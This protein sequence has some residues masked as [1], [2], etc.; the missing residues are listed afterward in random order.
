MPAIISKILENSIADEVG[1]AKGD[2]IL[3]INGQQPL[4]YIDY[5]FS[6]ASEDIV[7]EVQKSNFDIEII[8]I[9]KDFNE[10][11]GIVFESAI[12]DKIK[13]CTNKCI[14]CFVDQQPEGLRDSLYIK[15]DDYRLSYLQGTYVT[16]TNL[17]EKDRQRI[18]NLR[19]GPLYISVHTTNPDLRVK[20]LRNPKASKILEELSWLKKIKIPVHIQI[21]LCPGINDGR[22][23]ERTLVDLSNYKSIIKSI[24]VVPV[25]VTKYRKEKLRKIDKEVALKTIKQIENFNLKIKKNI[26]CASDEFFLTAD[27]EIPPTKY[28]GKFSQLEDGVGTLRLILDDF[29]KRIKKV[30]KRIKTPKK[31]TFAVSKSAYK[32]FSLFADELNKI[33]NLQIEII[34]V[35]SNY[36][37]SDI[38]VAGLICATDIIEQLKGRE[39]KNL[40]ISSV[41]LKAYSNE[42][43][44]GKTTD[45]IEKNLNCRIHIIY[46]FYSTKEIFQMIFG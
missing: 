18:E 21:V 42:F 10:D 41:M 23:L 39:I 7:L 34:P 11:L 22:E 12:F 24:A 37:G 45:D 32:V 13:P 35:K 43:L 36:W 30:P 27:A 28:Y 25:G 16:L 20:M 46:D 5:N 31:F 19:L 2:V 44:D 17:N 15:D 9:E 3:K 8:E 4:D 6:V 40:V 33:V 26:A 14:F 38:N 1:L 29:H